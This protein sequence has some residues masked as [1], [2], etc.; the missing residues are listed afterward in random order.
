MLAENLLMFGEEDHRQ[1]VEKWLRLQ[2]QVILF[3]CL[4]NGKW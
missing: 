3:M 2:N 4:G 1:G